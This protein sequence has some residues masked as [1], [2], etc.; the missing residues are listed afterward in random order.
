[1]IMI[2][3]PKDEV[4]PP[5]SHLKWRPLPAGTSVLQSPGKADAGAMPSAAHGSYALATEV[6]QVLQFFQQDATGPFWRN[7]ITGV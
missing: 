7:L 3:G 4:G 1:M 5:K 2:R 6:T